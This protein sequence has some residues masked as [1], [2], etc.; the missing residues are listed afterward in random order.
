MS[1]ALQHPWW[2][3]FV[4]AGFGVALSYWIGRR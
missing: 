3:P 4:A 2:M 1:E